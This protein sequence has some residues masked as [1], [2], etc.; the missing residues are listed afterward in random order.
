MS[1]SNYAMQRIV[2]KITFK[3]PMQDAAMEEKLY[4]VKKSRSALGVPNR[5]RWGHIN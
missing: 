2:W 3:I 1:Q 5:R 4:R